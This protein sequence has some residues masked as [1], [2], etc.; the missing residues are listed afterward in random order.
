MSSIRS[1]TN[2]IG[3][4][5]T[6]GRVWWSALAALH[7]PIFLRVSAGL[8]TGE[9]DPARLA[10]WLGLLLT[11]GF[12]ALKAAD[13]RFLRLGS[14]R[15]SVVAF[16]VVCA[17]VHEGS[18]GKT[19]IEQA[20]QAAALAAPLVMVAAA[21]R[22][23][24]RLL[25]LLDGVVGGTRAGLSAALVR[26]AERETAERAERLMASMTHAPP[27]APPVIA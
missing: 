21:V 3:R 14:R 9:A 22:F 17:L 16:L 26:F 4:H 10:S 8:L 1:L 19:L 23:R 27:R 18:T 5:L 6:L 13:V 15:A 25:E 2:W 11:L 24:K 20:P 12:F 7:T